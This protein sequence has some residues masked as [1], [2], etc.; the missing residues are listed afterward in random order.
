MKSTILKMCRRQGAAWVVILGLTGCATISQPPAAK[1]YPVRC[2]AETGWP[3]NLTMEQLKDVPV[4]ELSHPENGIDG[5]AMSKGGG[6]NYV[7]A[8]TWR[9]FTRFTDWGYEPA[10]NADLQLSGWLIKAG[11]FIPFLEK[12]QPSRTSFVHNLKMD[13]ALLAILPIDL[14]PQ[15]SGE[16]I[17]AAQKA[18]GE[19]KSW[20]D[21][22]PQTK[23][24]KH[25]RTMIQLEVDGWMIYI[26]VLAYGDF[27]HDGCEDM[28]VSVTHE[29]IHGTWLTTSSIILTRRDSRHALVRINQ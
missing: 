15:V 10:D 23:I 19:R 14:G 20:R 29:A 18:M 21:F 2:T 6:T 1:T 28:L 24:R 7:V 17:E 16:E 25:T 27:D 5:V 26:R 3:T 4:A 11:G 13:R 12:A 22:Y 8:R 9:E